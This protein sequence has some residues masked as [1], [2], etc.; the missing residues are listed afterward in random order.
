M[1]RSIKEYQRLL[2]DVLW[3]I[4]QR[5]LWRNGGIVVHA[6]LERYDGVMARLAEATGVDK[7]E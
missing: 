2:H 5:N 4:R 1:K 6:D 3:A 7:V